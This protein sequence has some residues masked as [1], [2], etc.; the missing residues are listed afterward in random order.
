[1][2]WKNITHGNGDWL[3]YVD[4]ERGDEDFDGKTWVINHTGQRF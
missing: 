4:G 2:E 3:Y 1:M